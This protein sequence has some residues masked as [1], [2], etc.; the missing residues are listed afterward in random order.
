MAD[1]Y[2]EQVSST[3]SDG[4]TLDRNDGPSF[5]NGDE[6]LIQDNSYVNAT[7]DW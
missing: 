3:D 5:V 6:Q 4:E 2:E 7:S 1:Y